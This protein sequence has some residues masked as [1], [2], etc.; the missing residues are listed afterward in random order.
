MMIMIK[1][2][3]NNVNKTRTFEIIMHTIDKLKLLAI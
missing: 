1:I 2:K 3:I